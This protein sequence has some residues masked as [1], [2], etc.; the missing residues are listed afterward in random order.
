MFLH[1]CIYF[2]VTI[3]IY[4]HIFQ[5]IYAIFFQIHTHTHL[6]NEIAVEHVVAAKGII[7]NN[8]MA[9]AG[10][11]ESNPTPMSFNFRAPRVS[12]IG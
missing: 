2:V 6:N 10:I 7:L 8:L 11:C 5:L 12:S 9:Y 3:C 4:V 1:I